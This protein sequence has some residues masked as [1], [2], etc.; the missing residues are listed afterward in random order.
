MTIT[1][2]C[3]L[4][5]TLPSDAAAA[6]W[7]ATVRAALR[8]CRETPDHL[9]RCLGA[10]PDFAMGWAAKGLFTLLLGR[11]ELAPLA[12]EAEAKA[13]AALS[14]VGG[15]RRERAYV[16]A[17]GAWLAGRPRHA[18]E[19]LSGVLTA[20]PEDALALK[21]DHSLR[22]LLGDR[23]GMLREA[24]A[25]LPAYGPDHPLA[26][27]ALGCHAFALEEMGAYALAEQAGRHGLE[28]TPDD[29]WGLHAVA[30][31]YDMTAQNETGIAWLEGQTAR[32]AH[33]NNFGAHLWWHLG[34]FHLDRGEI[35]RVLE[36][37]DSHVR[38][39]HTDDY[40]DIANGASMLVRLEIEGIEV[41]DRWEELAALAAGRVEDGAVV[42]ADLHYLL[43]LGGGERDA[44]AERLLARLAADAA[45]REH[46]MHEVAAVAGH[47]AAVG[48]VAFRA[49]D[50]ATAFERLRG[51]RCDM[52]R[53]GGSHAQRDVF[54]R[55]MIEAGIRAGRWAEA[56]SE[57]R[58]RVQRRGAED[59][60]TRRRLAA[61]G[62]ARAAVAA[63]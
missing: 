26:G 29:A 43:A 59:G 23:R 49:G 32:W 15:S 9:G 46:D 24:A 27:Y 18:A 52:Q 14:R 47:P 48:L 42:F 55:L 39:E 34:L 8:H 60:F 12:R 6:S 7:N 31:V 30:H 53:I 16:I 2:A 62:R 22:F 21:L 5:V 19:I 45:R 41:G 13:Q 58:A 57:I 10:A 54:S 44:E 17:L 63:E 40:R 51:V 37:Y 3:G 1:D 35:D 33:C 20:A 56:E 25:A 11:S 61:L 50:Y 28:R 38:A 4:A 36:L